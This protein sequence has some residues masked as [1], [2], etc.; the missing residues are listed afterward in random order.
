VNTPKSYTDNFYSQ[1][2]EG[3]LA[4]AKAIIPLV[5]EFITPFSVLDIGCGR[6]EWLS[7]WK[8]YG[9]KT[10]MGYDGPFVKQK[11]LFIAKEEFLVCDL[12]KEIKSKIKYDIVTC[13]EVAEHLKMETADQFIN[14]LCKTGD[15]ILFSA[16]IPGQEGTLH[17]NEQYP[18]YW[19]N[20]FHKN[21]FNEYDC[22]RENIWNNKSISS[23]Y[24]QNILVFIRKSEINKYPLIPKNKTGANALIHPEIFEYKLCKIA[25]YERILRNPITASGY[26]LKKYIKTLISLFKK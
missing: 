11:E 23:W 13:L 19:V 20:L 12:E 17:L 1:H 2:T 9:V 16:A 25:Y 5:L 7:V 6:G 14:S 15:F 4:S 10:V 21:S 24:R 8:Q 22:L 3:S 26:F 18:D